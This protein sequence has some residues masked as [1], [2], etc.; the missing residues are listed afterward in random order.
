MKIR[1]INA[2]PM[3]DYKHACLVTKGKDISKCTY[4]ENEEAE[5]EYWV[6]HIC[7]EHSTLRNIHFVLT[8]EIPKSCVMQIIRA[9]KEHP[10]PE[11]CSSRPDWTGKER[12]NDPYELKLFQVEYTPLGFLAMCRQ[13]LCTKTEPRTRKVVHGWVA[14]MCLSDNALIRA[15]GLCA[16]PQCSYHGGVCTELE[17]CGLCKKN[18]WEIILAK[19]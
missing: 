7:T 19:H 6:K 10:Q 3:F 8:D 16:E 2:D 9:T 15:I 11:V 18:K 1:I 14:Q 5:V 17:P 12:S 13:R 4:P